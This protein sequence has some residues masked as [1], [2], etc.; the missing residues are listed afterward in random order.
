MAPPHNTLEITVARTI[1]NVI[2]VNDEDARLHGSQNNP[3]PTG[4]YLPA[5]LLGG[6]LAFRGR[7]EIVISTLVEFWNIRSNDTLVMYPS[8][9]EDSA[10][11]CSQHF[12]TTIQL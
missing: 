11:R 2:C 3:F 1:G 4:L 6:I 9:K 7:K 10:L 12:Q 5:L 8:N